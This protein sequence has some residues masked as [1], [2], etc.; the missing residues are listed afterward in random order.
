MEESEFKRIV[1]KIVILERNEG[2]QMKM[3]LRILFT[4]FIMYN[5]D[6]FICFAAPF[7]PN[8]YTSV[9]I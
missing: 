2:I 7:N 1:G 9:E 6:G 8:Q 5:I 3:V 4:A